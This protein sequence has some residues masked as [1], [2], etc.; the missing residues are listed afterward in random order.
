MTSIRLGTIKHQTLSGQVLE[1]KVSI[2]KETERAI[3]LRIEKRGK[4]A[5][6]WIPKSVCTVHAKAITIEDWFWQKEMGQ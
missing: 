6:H 4:V 5:E 2:K 1:E 3:L